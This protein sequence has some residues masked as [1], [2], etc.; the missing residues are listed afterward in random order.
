MMMNDSLLGAAAPGFDAPLEMLR[1]CH[2][3]IEAQC[4]TLEK[5]QRHLA[6]SGCDEAAQQA[7]AGVL[8]YFDTAGR[9]HHAD[10]EEDLFPMLLQAAPAEAATLVPVLLAE[11]DAMEQAWDAL[12]KALR[13][14][15]AGA[16]AEFSAAEVAA[17]T[18]SYARHIATENSRL[19]P[20]AERV[21]TMEQRERLGRAMSERRGVRPRDGA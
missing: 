16:C 2:G 1:A 5:L 21:L 10:E 11:H 6:D 9:H 15:A 3:R 8:R 12:R 18:S 17:F 19:L 4:R 20:L 7:A 13:K 14:I